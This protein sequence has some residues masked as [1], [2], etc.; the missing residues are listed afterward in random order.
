ME[1][2]SFRARAAVDGC[3][4][5]VYAARPKGAG[6]RPG[7]LVFME[8]FGVNAH[9]RSVVD[10]WAAE[11]FF[12]AAADLYHR[13]DPG[14]EGR[15]T[16][17]APA[18]ANMDKLTHEGLEADVRAAH[19]WLSSQDGID[20]PLS[21]VGYCLGGKV[22]FLASA[23]V[24]LKA[25]VSYYGGGIP[26]ILDRAPRVGAP[27]LLLWGGL[28]KSIPPSQV[29]EVVGALRAH[30]KRHVSAEFSSAEHAFNCDLRAEYHPAAAK[31]AWA[32]ASAFLREP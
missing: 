3:E 28:D 10:R 27:L 16:E 26:A 25:A 7:L 13:F 1:I 31:Q 15:Y 23:T 24:P 18:L 29:S 5:G 32:L 4:M 6:R 21:C 20:G 8:A 14:F 30:G 12:A 2:E 17:R 11:G 22:S 9:I 19:A